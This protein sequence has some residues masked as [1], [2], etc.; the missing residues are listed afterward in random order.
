LCP[1]RFF[2][3][4]ALWIMIATTVAGFD[5]EKAVDTDGR[6]EEPVVEYT[7]G[8]LRC[9]LIFHYELRMLTRSALSFKP[10]QALQI[11]DHTAIA[12]NALSDPSHCHRLLRRWQ[13]RDAILTAGMLGLHIDQ[14]IWIYTSV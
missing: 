1:G 3:L 10:R 2:A 11:Q 7:T 9:D 5:I 14:S 8:F 4:E 13:A 12:R 6:P